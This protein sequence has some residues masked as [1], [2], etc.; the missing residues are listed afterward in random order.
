MNNFSRSFDHCTGTL[1]SA[2]GM[3]ERRHQVDSC[4]LQ[5]VSCW[6]GEKDHTNRRLDYK[7][8]TST[9][10]PALWL[11]LSQV[12]HIWKIAPMVMAGTFQ[13]TY[14]N[15]YNWGD[16]TIGAKSR[17]NSWG[18]CPSHNMLCP[19]HN[20]FCPSY[21]MNPVITFNIATGTTYML[22]PSSNML[23]LEQIKCYAPTITFNI[24]TGTCY[25]WSK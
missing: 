15:G 8:T 6:K 5:M 21:N 1:S 20:M 16:V 25:A 9:A 11:A 13:S 14:K 4:S 24:A 12:R 17:S 2:T 10:G 7:Y 18:S 22:W 3:V 19:S 23:W